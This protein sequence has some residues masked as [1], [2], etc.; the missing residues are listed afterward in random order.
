[1][2]QGI[3]PKPESYLK[4]CQRLVSLAIKLTSEAT[5]FGNATFRA[6]L[7]KSKLSRRKDDFHLFPGRL[8]MP[9]EE[10]PKII[11]F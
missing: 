9:I 1:M 3:K 5:K 4:F 6:F 7:L 8:S 10:I 2:N 11:P